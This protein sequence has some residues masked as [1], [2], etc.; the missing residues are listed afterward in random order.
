MSRLLSTSALA[1]IALASPVF[2]EVTPVQVWDRMVESQTRW[3][4]QIT[5]GAREE[6]GDTLTITDVRFRSVTQVPA[7]AED[8]AAATDAET[9][10]SMA[11]DGMAADGMAADG[12]A[13]DG[14]AAD[15]PAAE[16]MATDGMA[17]DGMTADTPATDTPA[18]DAPAA[19]GMAADGAEAS[20]EPE[21]MEQVVDIL[22]PKV[23]LTQTGDG[24][25]R[26]V[27]EGD[28]TATMTMEGTEAPVMN[29]TLAMPGNEIVTTGAPDAMNHAF[30]YPTIDGN[31]SLVSPEEGTVP[32]VLTMTGLKGTYDVTGAAGAAQD[33]AY[34]MTGDAMQVAID[35]PAPAEGTAPTEGAASGKVVID[36]ATL[37][38]EGT[39]KTPAG[40]YDMSSQMHE[41]LKAGLSME[42]TMSVASL[43]T[44]ID[45]T[46]VNAEG[47]PAN[48]KGKVTLADLAG[49]FAMS[50][51]KIRYEIATGKLAAEMTVPDMPMPVSYGMDSVKLN[52]AVPVTAAEAAQPFAFAYALKGVTLGDA[53]WGMVDPAAQIPRDPMD[54]NV[55]LDGD[56]ILSHDLLDEKAAAEM[57]ASEDAAMPF[58]LRRLTVK[59]ISLKAAGATADVAGE[60]TV[61][62]GGT[63]DAP[64]GKLN[65]NVT[66]ANALIDR[67]AAMGFVP[68]EQVAGVK[69]MLMAF[70]KPVEGK[71][72]AFT[73][74]FEFR[75]GGSIFANGQQVK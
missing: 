63:F 61:P 19:E 53:I 60:L 35:M 38:S 33:T 52:L 31:I 41:A 58:D 12:M 44:D 2:A 42:G 23:V 11:A 49:G 59:D 74:E 28:V 50:A 10:E 67:L 40:S 6:A 20:A 13:A 15:A 27:Y 66:G 75:E 29:M 68:Q 22:V 24:G 47:Q 57:A 54:L 69:M 36:L 14:M 8:E 25:V 56:L 55:D 30:T 48:T 39:F 16:G 4:Y 73:T 43:T 46:E 71:E 18:T 64:L 32:V 34:K 7:P 9:P 62:E 37:G 51:E 3:G 21:M 45:L 70:A 26:T 1:M 72:D 65:A 17:A 5:E